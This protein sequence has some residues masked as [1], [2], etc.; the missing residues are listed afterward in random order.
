MK[1]EAEKDPTGETLTADWLSMSEPEKEAALRA[2]NA[3]YSKRHPYVP[4]GEVTSWWKLVWEG[5][6]WFCGVLAFVLFRRQ[7]EALVSYHFLI[8]LSLGTSG[9]VVYLLH[10][11]DQS[12]SK[13]SSLEKRLAA[14]EDS[15]LTGSVD[16]KK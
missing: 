14:I 15:K 4:T 2:W 5:L 3:D 13:M 11:L 8:F 1:Y 7:I 12:D 10:R 9:I 6:L 16:S